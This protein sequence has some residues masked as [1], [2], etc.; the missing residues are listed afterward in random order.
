MNKEEKKPYGFCRNCGHPFTEEDV[1][2]EGC[3][4][5]LSAIKES[6]RQ[7]E[8]KKETQEHEEV[9]VVKKD[10]PKKKKNR[11][12]VIGL[13][14]LLLIAGLGVGGFYLKQYLDQEKP[15]K[16][17][18]GE[19]YYVYLKEMKEENKEKEAGIPEDLKDAK[20]NFYEVSDLDDPIM[21]LDYQ[22]DDKTYSNIYYIE[23]EKVNA[24]IYQ[25][26]TEVELLYNVKEKTYDYYTHTNVEEKDSYKKVSEQVEARS[27]NEEESS[28]IEEVPEYVFT[29]DDVET[30]TDDDGNKTEVSKFDT[31]FVKVEQDKKNS[32]E[33]EKDLTEK[34][35]KD[36]I[37]KGVQSYVPKNEIVDKNVE[38]EVEKKVEEAT[39]KQ[40]QIKK[41][42][43]E[44]EKKGFKV[45][46]HY[47]KYGTYKSDIPKEELGGGT[48]TL[49]PDG[50]FVY[51]NTWK[52]YTG[53]ATNV[54]R[55]GTYKAEYSKGDM[56][57]STQCWMI[58]FYTEESNEKYPT[59]TDVYDVLEDNKFTA[60]Q[61]SNTWTPVE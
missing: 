53:E 18:W 35:L 51:E 36:L 2:C 46:D 3:G 14:I 41:I 37:D 31:T 45:G 44:I 30:V 34:E 48:Y 38:K 17:A 20:L 40:E 15:M 39:E 24:L 33:Y 5:D 25:E 8:Q 56:Y 7:R 11:N 50:T 43:E 58:I 26:P 54:R 47:L 28:K 52:D 19:S 21:V 42:K 29:K 9:E 10:I 55:T 27:E 13:V 32:I 57:D 61:Y 60:R 4:G 23:D 59:K 6:I 12:L 1:F 22:K 16:E 49:N